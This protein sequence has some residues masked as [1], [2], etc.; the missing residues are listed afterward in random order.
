[1]ANLNMSTK[2]KVGDVIK[3]N[4][5]LEVN[6]CGAKIAKLRL[7]VAKFIVLLGAKIGGF[8]ISFRSK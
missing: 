1:M 2:I 4:F 7:K 5:V 6:V 8:Q 3:D